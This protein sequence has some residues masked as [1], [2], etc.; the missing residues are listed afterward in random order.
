MIKLPR[1]EGISLLPLRPLAKLQRWYVFNAATRTQTSAIWVQRFCEVC[2]TISTTERTH[3][4]STLYRERGHQLETFCAGGLRGIVSILQKLGIRTT[5]SWHTT[6]GGERPIRPSG[7]G[8][9]LTCGIPA[10]FFGICTDR[11]GAGNRR[12]PPLPKRFTLRYSKKRLLFIS[13]QVFSAGAKVV[14]IQLLAT[15]LVHTCDIL[16]RTHHNE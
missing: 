13:K 6:N 16:A 12:V 10:F 14:E 7:C 5:K 15:S 1:W 11:E 2:V 8:F 4:Y 3:T 9:L